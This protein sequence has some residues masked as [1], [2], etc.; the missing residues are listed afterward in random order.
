M[1]LLPNQDQQMIAM[2]RVFTRERDT[3]RVQDANLIERELFEM[4]IGTL[5]TFDM[6]G[7]HAIAFRVQILDTG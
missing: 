2:Q 3:K 1:F 4:S 5:F 7:H 6:I